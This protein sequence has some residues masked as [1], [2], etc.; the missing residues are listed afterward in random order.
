[1]KLNSSEERS[2]EVHYKVEFDDNNKVIGVDPSSFVMKN[3][4]PKMALAALVSIVFQWI[5][6]LAKRWAKI[7]TQSYGDLK[8]ALFDEVLDQLKVGAKTFLSK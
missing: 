2:I 5:G 8:A 7:T 6:N 4:N 1:M 3:I